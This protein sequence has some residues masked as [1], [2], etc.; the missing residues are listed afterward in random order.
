MAIPVQGAV[1]V[2]NKSI[3]LFLLITCLLSWPIWVFSGVL[4]RGG[5]GAYDIHWLVAQIGVFG[6]ALA[7]LLVSSLIDKTLIRNNLRILPVLLLPLFLPGLLVAH[8]SPSRIIDLSLTPSM[9]AIAVGV[10]IVLIFFPVN[11]YV[12]SPGTGKRQK[13]PHSGWVILSVTLLP[14]LFL[15]AWLLANARGGTLEI[16]AF[17]GGALG[18]IW[19]VLTAFSHNL[20]LG[21]SLGEEIG[22]RGFLLPALLGRMSPLWASLVLGVVWGLWHLPIDLYAGFGSEGLGAVLM[23]V[24]YVLPLSVIFTWF[25]L[26]TDGSLLIALFLHTSLNIMGD[27]G[28]SGFETTGMIFFLLMA[29]TA[30]AIFAS[31]AVFRRRGKRSTRTE[32]SNP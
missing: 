5:T 1:R 4:P 3:W 2:S 27:L 8:A 21:G 18:S 20:L 14:S 17:K 24:I 25:Y 26:H 15:V 30:V 9:V 16:S 13:K 31:S 11:R 22:W 12:V 29:V 28:L 7:A 23:R 10:L 32:W 19:I 6:P